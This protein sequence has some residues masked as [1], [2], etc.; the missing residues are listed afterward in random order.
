MWAYIYIWAFSL[1]VDRDHQRTHTDGVRSRQ[2]TCLNFFMP[3]KSFNKPFE[4]LL[5]K[6]N[7]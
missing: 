3:Q 7:R 1:V 4:F 5:Y 2:Q 6:T